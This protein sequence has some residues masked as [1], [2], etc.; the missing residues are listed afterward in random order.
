MEDAPAAH[1]MAPWPVRLARWPLKILRTLFRVIPEAVDGY[2]ADRCGQHAAG[3]AY[4]V[5][6]SLVPLSIVLVAI[7]GLV[8]RD[9][10]LRDDVIRQIVD[11]LP[12]SDTGSADVTREIEKLARPATGLGIVSL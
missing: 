1:G 3:I 12:L 2:F 6:F 10:S 11:T 4:R 8:L 7:F 9:D 5:L